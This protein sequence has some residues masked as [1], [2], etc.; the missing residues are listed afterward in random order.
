MAL[1]Q[2]DPEEGQVVLPYLPAQPMPWT[3]SR[4]AMPIPAPRLTIRDRP[5]VVDELGVTP[6]YPASPLALGYDTRIRASSDAAEGLMGP[7]DGAWVVTGADGKALIVLQLVDPGDGSGRLEGAWRDLMT[8][9]GVEPVGL[10]DSLE[11]GAGDLT[12]R[13]QPRGAASGVTLQVRPDS[14]GDW[15]GQLIDG[16]QVIPV[17]MRPA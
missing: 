17:S 5:T 7:L 8:P 4:R 1:A 12:I 14:S 11:R 10:I 13:F 3:P 6:E 9:D 2:D 15:S 16:A